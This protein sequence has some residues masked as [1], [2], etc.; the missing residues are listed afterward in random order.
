MVKPEAP[1]RGLP[2][3]TAMKESKMPKSV[4]VADA[5]GKLLSPEDFLNK[6]M[7]MTKEEAFKKACPGE[8][9]APFTESE[10]ERFATALREYS[11]E[12]QALADQI[13]QAE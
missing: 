11:A 13:S 7:G 12:L 5:I 1:A 6:R 3:I 9:D 10:A 2:K 4:R 8:G